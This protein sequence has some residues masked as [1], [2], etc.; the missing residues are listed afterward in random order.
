LLD[1]A[2]KFS[3]DGGQVL[4]ALAKEGRR[5]PRVRI[6]VRDEG[7]GLPSD[8]SRLFRPFGQSGEVN[9]RG[10]E[11]GGVGVG[12]SIVKNLVD[13][14]DGSVHAESSP[15]GSRFIVRLPAAAD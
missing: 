2:V 8:T 5:H 11:E 15:G 4:V 13:A 12:L 10:A 1:N 9:T 3:P 7:I 6:E 14:M